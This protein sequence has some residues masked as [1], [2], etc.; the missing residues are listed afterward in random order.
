MSLRDFGVLSDG[1]SVQEVTLG[2]GRLT[3]QFLTFGARING[4]SFDEIDDLTPTLDLEAASGANPYS[5]VIVGPVMNRLGSARAPLNEQV[6]TF[7]ANEGSNLLHSGAAGLH[8]LV[9][10]IAEVSETTVTFA[11]DLPPDTF[12]GRRRIEVTYRLEDADLVLE[13]TGTTDAPTLMNV[14]FHPFWTVSGRGRAGHVLRVHAAQYLPM[15]DG[16]VP[17]GEIADVVGTALDYR[18]ARAPADD[19]DHCFVLP[20]HDGIAPCVTLVSDVMRLEILS[21]APAV[22]V[23]T[24]M[25]IGI[26]VEPEIHPDAPNHA[27]FPSILLGSGE[28]F[29]QT[30][31]H[32]FSRR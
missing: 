11:V 23:F 18:T 27:G 21:D 6:L 15:D 17:T 29:R 12:P 5:G 32:R 25:D 10:D 14:G 9:W 7:D 13:I 30:V 19:I 2:N 4:L 24:C 16:K 3:A 1:R 22:H 8:R 31:I 26:A 20:E 28:T